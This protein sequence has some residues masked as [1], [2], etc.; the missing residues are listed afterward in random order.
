MTRFRTLLA[1]TTVVLFAVSA[2]VASA[3]RLVHDLTGNWSFSV[4]TEN[5]TG[6]PAVTLKQEGDKLT[7]TYQSNMMGTREFNGSLK[8]DSV[9]LTL[10]A[11]GP[12]GIALEFAGV[13][14]DANNL[15]GVVDFGGMG[16]ADFT[17]KRVP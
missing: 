5:G 9:K 15:A 10:A 4:V 8:G 13:V 6:T 11:N 16:G 14:V 12:D 17:G 1:I 3:H 2:G 7:G